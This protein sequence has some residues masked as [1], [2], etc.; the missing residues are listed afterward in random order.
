MQT[1]TV[2]LPYMVVDEKRKQV[3]S[4]SYTSP[5]DGGVVSLWGGFVEANS[6]GREREGAES[7]SKGSVC[8]LMFVYDECAGPMT[9]QR[10]KQNA[11]TDDDDMEMV[12]CIGPCLV[13]R[14]H[15]NPMSR[16]IAFKEL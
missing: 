15:L 2:F 6:A 16:L 12:S 11:G 4:R 7:F 9:T 5:K 8:S 3:F 13:G 1:V 10:H 14:R